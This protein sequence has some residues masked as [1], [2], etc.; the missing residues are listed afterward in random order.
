[1]RLECPLTALYRTFDAS[2]SGFYAWAKAA[3]SQRLR[4]DERLKVA[5]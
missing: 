5:I 4:D 1:M 3:P 2:R